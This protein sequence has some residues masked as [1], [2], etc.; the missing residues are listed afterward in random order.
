MYYSQIKQDEFIDNFFKGK[1]NGIFIDVGANDGILLS[2]TYFFEKEKNWTGICI[3]PRMDEYLKLTQNRKC[4]CINSA[5]SDCDGTKDFLEIVGHASMLSGLKENY[6][7]KHLKRMHDEIQSGG[8][9]NTIQMQVTRLQSILDKYNVYDIDYC[10]IDV[11]GAEL[12]V[13]KSIDFSKTQIKIFTIENN[14]NTDE[15]RNYLK[16]YNYILYKQLE[17]DDIFIK[18]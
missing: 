18:G 13:I 14:Y 9:C 4:L 17:I 2:N 12:D 5:I 7:V 6:D 8:F 11:E 10:S 16:N 3:E 1:R 15:V